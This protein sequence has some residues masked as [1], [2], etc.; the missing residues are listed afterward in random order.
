MVRSPIGWT[1]VGA[2]M[3]VIVAVT[4]AP[5]ATAPGAAAVFTTASTFLPGAP[6][7]PA[8]TI[9]RGQ[10]LVFVN[11]SVPSE[12]D[13]H[14]IVHLDAEPRFS[15]TIIEPGQAAPVSGVSAL[16]PGQYPFLCSL[17]PTTMRGTLVVGP[18]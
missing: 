6:P 13:E 2:T 4:P 9:A 16:P 1:R 3:A 10:S 7:A 15:S 11:A 17:H 12:Q 8:V 14:D 18:G 5:A